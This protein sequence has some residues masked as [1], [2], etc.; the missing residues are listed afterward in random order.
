MTDERWQLAYAI[1]EAAAPLAEAERPKYVQAAAP[2]AEI[3]EKVLAMLAEMKA[4]ASP[5][6]FPEA[7]LSTVTVGDPPSLNLPEGAVLG[8][9]VVTGFVGRG[10]MG[11][12]YSAH[13]PELNR[14]EVFVDTPWHMPQPFARELDLSLG[15]EEILRFTEALCRA[16]PDS[17]PYNEWR[18]WADTALGGTTRGEH[19]SGDRA[20]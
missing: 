4:A 13:D 15:D 14:V 17:R 6:A 8:R 19:D 2:D 10:G 12:V 7:A 3:A 20:G 9:F 5:G 1:Y 16:N 18:R 11:T